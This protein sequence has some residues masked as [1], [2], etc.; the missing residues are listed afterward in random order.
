MCSNSVSK[1]GAGAN[2]NVPIKIVENSLNGCVRVGM[3]PKRH[4]MMMDDSSSSSKYR[5]VDKF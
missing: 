1:T 4:S 3:R 5:I 2:A